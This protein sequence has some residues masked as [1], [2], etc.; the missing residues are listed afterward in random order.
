MKNIGL[1][2]SLSRYGSGTYQWTI[3][4]LHALEDYRKAHSGVSKM[5]ILCFMARNRITVN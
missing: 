5:V 2:L 1:V 4:I 3:N